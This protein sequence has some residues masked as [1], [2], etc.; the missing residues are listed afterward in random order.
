MA[1]VHSTFLKKTFSDVVETNSLEPINLEVTNTI[2]P[3]L[4]MD[5]NQN[6]VRSG[7][8][9]GT[10]FTT[11]S[12]YDFWLTTIFL[13]CWNDTTGPTAG[14]AA[15]TF[16]PR[17]GSAVTYKVQTD[18]AGNN[19]PNAVSLA[20]PMRGI[21]LEKNSAITISGIAGLCDIVITGYTGSDR[22]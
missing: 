8:T 9:T 11:P 4:Q 10:L 3:V 5:P 12:Q 15:L 22:S 2:I 14:L 17:G 1:G 21:L 18:A 20:F 6:I 7:D 13:S 16:T 19:G